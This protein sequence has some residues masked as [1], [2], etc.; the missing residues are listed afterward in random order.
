MRETAHKDLIENFEPE[1]TLSGVSPGW[2]GRT[3][4]GNAPQSV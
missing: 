4:T 2:T 3:N 1:G